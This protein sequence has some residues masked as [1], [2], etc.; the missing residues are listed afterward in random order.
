MLAPLRNLPADRR[1]LFWAFTLLECS[2]LGLVVLGLA[3]AVKAS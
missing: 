1:R 3:L 2:A